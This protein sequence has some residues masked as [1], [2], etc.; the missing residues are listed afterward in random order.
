M[1]VAALEWVI[2]REPRNFIARWDYAH[3]QLA[4]R[5]FAAGWPNYEYRLQAQEGGAL[6]SHRAPWRGEVLDGKTLLVLGEQGIGDQIMFAS[7]LA[8][9]AARARQCI[10]VCEPRLVA[11]FERSFPGVIVRS[12]QSLQLAELDRADLEV[13]AGS[14]P[15]HFRP[16]RST[17]PP[18]GYLGRPDRCRTGA[19]GST[20]PARGCVGISWRRGGT[21]RSASRLRSI[22]LAEL[23]PLM[24]LPEAGF[25]SL[26]YGDVAA[27]LAD[28]ANGIEVLD[29]PRRS[30]TTTRRG[31]RDPR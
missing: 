18:Q 13:Q 29:F 21:A 19:S 7:C 10:L 4:A 8:E 6:T 9:V 5:D 28:C 16:P 24:A 30:A 25:V 12:L 1:R 15:G 26:Q 31:A 3:L 20:R 2:A 27:E 14:L 11:L 17:F 22:P 23:A